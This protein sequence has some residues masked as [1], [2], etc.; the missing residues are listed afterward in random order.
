MPHL[1]VNGVTFPGEADSF[2]E[3][4]EWIG[5]VTGRSQSGALVE[6]RTTR[7][8][9]WAV[10]SVFLQ[11]AEAE[12]W[13]LMLEGDGHYWRL[14]TN[15]VS[16][17][18]LGAS[19]GGT[20]SF[21]TF[22]PPT[23]N[24]PCISVGAGSSV[25]WALGSVMGPRWTPAA[26]FTLSV[27]RQDSTSSGDATSGFYRYLVTGSS[28]WALGTA[29]PAG[30]T[31]YRDGTAGTYGVGE[32]L[33]LTANGNLSLHGKG[34]SAGASHAHS[35]A[36][37]TALPFALPS[38]WVASLNAYTDARRLAG[39]PWISE[40][41]R[42]VLAGDAIPDTNGANVVARVQSLDQRNVV[43]GGAHRNNARVLTVE[44]IEV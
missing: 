21:A 2:A 41:P 20:F 23:G 13:R 12:A 18:G 28:A 36:Y 15:A 31:Q 40:N 3:S 19:S 17:K 16:S 37:L 10:R 39:L 44:F 26:G 25:S 7:K 24:T 42:V 22:T 11:A 8:R 29:N 5:D 27:Y 4:P 33:E 14:A 6:S 34:N 32:W 43:L 30:V 1:T 35:Y 38:G 9:R